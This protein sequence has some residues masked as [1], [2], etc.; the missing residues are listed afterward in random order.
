MASIADLVI[1]LVLNA[2]TGGAGAMKTALAEIEAAAGKAQAALN[3]GDRLGLGAT[4]LLQ[5]AGSDIMNVGAKIASVGGTLTK[6]VTVPLAAVGTAALKSAMDFETAFT[7][8]SKTVDGTDEQFATLRETIMQMSRETQFSQVEIANVMQAAGQLGVA[9]D[10]VADFSQVML[11]MGTATD[12]G[13][14]EAATQLAR[15]AAITGMPIS[16]MRNLGSAIVELG[17]NF[18]TTESE[19]VAMGLRLASAGR[20]AD[21]T[22]AS[23]MGL[24]AALTSVGLNAEAGGTAFSRVLLDISK[25]ADKGEKDMKDFAKV[26]GMS[27]KDFLALWKSDSTAG[28]LKF[29]EGL[30]QVKEQGGNLAG[31]LENLGFDDVRVRDTL[32]RS[33]GS[34][35]QFAEAIKTANKAFEENI[36]LQIEFDKANNTTAAKLSQLKNSFTEIGINLGTAMLPH[37]QG[38]ADGIAGAASKFADLDEGAQRAILTMAG[39]AAAAGPVTSAIGGV[40]SAVGGIAQAL[41][42]LAANPVAGLIVGVTAAVAGLSIALDS[43][44]TGAE[45]IATAIDNIQMD[46]GKIE[47]WKKEIEE[48]SINIEKTANLII[49]IDAQTEKIKQQIDAYFADGKLD[50]KEV[51]QIKQDVEVIINETFTETNKDGVVTKVEAALLTEL[52]ALQEELNGILDGMQGKTGQAAQAALDE[53]MSVLERI[54]TIRQRL[55]V[56]NSEMYQEQ[57]GSYNRITMGLGTEE[58]ITPATLHVKQEYEVELVN[59]TKD[60][61]EQH[62]EL[63]RQ[64][65]RAVEAGDTDEAGK[66]SLEITELELKFKVDKDQLRKDYLARMSKIFEGLGESLGDELL[67]PLTELGEK[68]DLKAKILAALNDLT[69]GYDIPPESLKS[70][71]TPEI[72]S[73]IFG[74]TDGETEAFLNDPKN[75]PINQQLGLYLARLLEFTDKDIEALI[76]QLDGNPIVE[77][78]NTLFDDDTFN[79][80]IENLDVGD[81]WGA[82]LD[83]LKTYD[84]K[85]KE[86]GNDF[87]QKLVDDINRSISGELTLPEGGWVLDASG[88]PVTI[89]NLKVGDVVYDLNGAQYEV[90]GIEENPETGAVVV[91]VKPTGVT[92]DLQGVPVIAEGAQG[93]FTAPIGSVS[94]QPGDTVVDLNGKKLTVT[95][96]TENVE[97]GTVTVTYTVGESTVDASG[98]EPE[99]TGAPESVEGGTI[100]ASFK[101][102][103]MTVDASGE[104]PEVTGAPES[105]ELDPI[106]EAT[107]KVEKVIQDVSGA[108]VET[109]GTP[110][111]PENAGAGYKVTTVA[112][113][114]GGMAAALSQDGKSKSGGKT[115]KMPVGVVQYDLSTATSSETTGT[116]P[117]LTEDAFEPQAVT[118]P[119]AVSFEAG[120]VDASAAE[121][122]IQAAV[123]ALG[124]P[125]PVTKPVDVTIEATPDSSAAASVVQAEVDS[126]DDPADVTKPVT[127]TLAVTVNDGGA[128]AAI[129]SAVKALGKAESVTKTVTVNVKTVEKKSSSGGSSGGSGGATVASGSASVEKL[130]APMSFASIMA[131]PLALEPLELETPVF[132]PLALEPLTLEPLLELPKLEFELPE[133]EFNAAA[134][135]AIR[136][137]DLSP[138]YD[139][140]IEGLTRLTGDLSGGESGKADKEEQAAK[141][142]SGVVQNV[143]INSPKALSPYETA[144]QLKKVAQ[145]LAT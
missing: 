112:S 105:V 67:K 82:L 44:P 13:A 39:I 21:M 84:L 102:E 77:L 59:I 53:A 86:L 43:I 2:N 91:N 12:L 40:V 93:E 65:N 118:L 88:K 98:E 96:V 141:E 70:I 121:T 143:T 62:A 57:L 25:A 32:M 22:D 48:G 94:L 133:L 119:V 108:V 61:K 100:A 68:Y 79:E 132:E 144:R 26:A 50:S 52:V 136:A 139:R 28:M 60:Y 51:K 126:L 106:P 127:V 64:F 46:E 42:W 54:E 124:E 14:T 111:E 63:M 109:T 58:D 1:N 5:Q 71:F 81:V 30:S 115:I 74:L 142:P 18:P 41:G 110:P 17:N 23:I 8:V 134:L 49:E 76:G 137:I 116:P 114:A 9:V 129:D 33:A 75:S 87:V 107:Q 117:E 83:A 7:G 6:A 113:G 35:E 80:A 24:S 20:Q 4:N 130:A 56:I 37:L 120:N 16:N 66:I 145:A 90:V 89:E 15:F 10:D 123:D 103:P 131:E 47:R 128:Q 101:A 138:N 45:R 92:I 95:G 27:A 19:I 31:T 3:G 140:L 125:E 104:D 72:L 36:A 73:Q 11:E 69:E 122:S 85:D 99:V 34:Y 55:A 38:M 135:A 78:L 97:G 29:V